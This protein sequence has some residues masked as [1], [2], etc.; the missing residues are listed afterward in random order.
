MLAA[1]WWSAFTVA[2]IWGQNFVPGV[3]LLAAGLVV[4]L[5]EQTRSK[6]FWLAVAW[7][8]LQE[9]IGSLAF[10]YGILW[11]GAL[12]AMFFL[13]RWL[14]EA[15]SI[16]FIGLIGIS[17]GVLHFAFTLTLASLEDLAL[18]QGRLLAESAL[19]VLTFPACWW[20]ADRLYPAR[21][22]KDERPL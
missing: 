8:V 21:L 22:K 11:Y 9:G 4:S 6:T 14:F 2:G 13:G 5:Q 7:I 17:L 12:T 15:K 19:Q 3:D 18:P 10:G 16:L 20:A 1:L